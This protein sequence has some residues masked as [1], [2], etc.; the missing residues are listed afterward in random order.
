MEVHPFAKMLDC[1]GVF[2]ALPRG[3]YVLF[4]VIHVFFARIACDRFDEAGYG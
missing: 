2:C 4:A 3:V 1:R